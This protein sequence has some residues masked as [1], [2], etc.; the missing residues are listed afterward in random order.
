M[1]TN[2]RNLPSRAPVPATPA[3]FNPLEAM[4]RARQVASQAMGAYST[5][6]NRQSWHENA[7]PLWLHKVSREPD[8]LNP[9]KFRWVCQITENEEAGDRINLAFT[10]NAWRDNYFSNVG[11]ILARMSGAALGPL[12]LVQIPTK[13]PN[14]AWDLIEWGTGEPANPYPEDQSDLPF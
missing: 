3:P 9:G 4:N 6:E 11:K 12:Q 1:S 8:N 10:A 13:G 2:N 14:P 5:A 7:T